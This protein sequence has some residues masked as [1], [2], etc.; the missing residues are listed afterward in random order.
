LGI[1]KPAI[2]YKVGDYTR[3]GMDYAQR[4]IK[5]IFTAVGA[6]EETRDLS[7]L[8]AN[9]VSGSGLITGTCRMG[10]DPKTSVVDSDCQSHDVKNLLIVGSTVFPTGGNTN[11]T[12][13]LA[14]LAFRAA[15]R[16]NQRLSP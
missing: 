2:A 14:A 10:S 1:P 11:P 6:P 8:K 7:A 9:F 16:I 5:L 15:A 3:K 12:V 13:T 4:A